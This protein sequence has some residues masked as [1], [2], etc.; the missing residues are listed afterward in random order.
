MS[1]PTFPKAGENWEECY[2]CGFAF[3]RSKV[4]RARSGPGRGKL[5]DIKCFDAMDRTD[6]MEKQTLPVENRRVSEQPVKNQ[7]PA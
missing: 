5:V 3:P 1:I 7:G 2:F 4:M 6:Y